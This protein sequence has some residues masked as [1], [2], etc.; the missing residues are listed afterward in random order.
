MQGAKDLGGNTPNCNLFA[1]PGFFFFFLSLAFQNRPSL[2]APNLL[3]TPPLPHSVAH[4]GPD[5]TAPDASPSGKPLWPRS[6]QADPI[7]RSMGVIG[8]RVESREK[9]INAKGEG[10]RSHSPS[11]HLSG[12]KGRLR[13]AA[14]SPHPLLINGSASSGS[15]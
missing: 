2:S 10:S 8:Q 12:G 7:S 1:S 5:Q 13:C 4:A 11:A 6:R 15:H 3:T 14:L 9:V